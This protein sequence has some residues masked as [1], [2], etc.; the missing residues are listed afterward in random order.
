[1]GGIKAVSFDIWNTLL[2][3]NPDFKNMRIKRIAHALGID[4]I[5]LV[6]KVVMSVDEACD[7][8]T[9]ITGEQFGPVDRLD[10]V[11][12]D[13]G[14]YMTLKSANKLISDIE[15]LFL[16]NPPALK[17]STIIPTFEELKSRGIKIAVLS[18]TG[19][20]NGNVMRKALKKLSIESYIDVS[21]FSNEIGYAKPHRRVF[22]HVILD[23]KC[24]CNTIVHVGDNKKAD[25]L[26]AQNAGLEALWLTDV[27]GYDHI[28]SIE[29]VLNY[30]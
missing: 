16:S 29:K 7:A 30:V 27:W 12:I 21:I 11:S 3:S 4:D 14:E 25:Y 22:E 15:S 24:K 9:D 8:E 19:F 18:N 13:L 28:D 5:D 1:M 10:R 20:I 26:G 6:T 23:L 17:E 2:K